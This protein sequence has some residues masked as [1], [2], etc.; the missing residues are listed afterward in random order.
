MSEFSFPVSRPKGRAL[1]VGG[2]AGRFEPA[3]LLTQLGYQCAHCEH[4]YEAMYELCQRPLA[5]RAL[6]LP[7][8]AVYLEELTLISAVKSRWSHIEVWLAQTDGRSAALAQAMRLG[9]DGLLDDEGLHR[10]ASAAMLHDEG[11]HKQDFQRAVS[12][13]EDA[14]S[15]VKAEAEAGWA[16]EAE[17]RKI[18]AAEAKHDS[19]E[20]SL[21]SAAE[22]ALG[23]PILTAEELKALL[24][25]EPMP[26]E[27]HSH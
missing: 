11:K 15:A 22:I 4:P 7:L 18:S 24:H 13:L 26:N 19:G 25:D 1:I 20:S 16:D 23:E 3:R 6:I 27:P 14:D 9:A 12:E 21:P 5:Y 17:H 10:M 2:N 8:Q